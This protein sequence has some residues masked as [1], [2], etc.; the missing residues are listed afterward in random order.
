MHGCEEVVGILL[1]RYVEIL[2][3]NI[4]WKSKLQKFQSADTVI[5]TFVCATPNNV[6]AWKAL[7]WLHAWT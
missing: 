1:E 6:S 7:M 2:Y 5:V 3:E 4:V